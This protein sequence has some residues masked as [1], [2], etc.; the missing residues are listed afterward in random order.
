M[1]ITDV[2]VAHR[3]A[4]GRFFDG[5]GRRKATVGLRRAHCELRRRTCFVL[6]RDQDLKALE[7][8]DQATVVDRDPS[9]NAHALASGRLSPL[10]ALEVAPVGRASCS[11][12]CSMDSLL[13]SRISLIGPKEFPAP[14]F[15]EFSRNQLIERDISV[16][17]EP[18]FPGEFAGNFF[19]TAGFPLHHR[20]SRFRANRR[21]NGSR[22]R[23]WRRS[24]F[25]APCCLL[26]WEKCWP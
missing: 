17:R 5:S 20:R 6:S 2:M 15:R 9:R 10:L 14:L 7:M 18:K 1:T 8:I 13:R 26:A 23:L 24:R 12:F 4:R 25:A 21:A 16:Q 19:E 22:K 11:R 3:K